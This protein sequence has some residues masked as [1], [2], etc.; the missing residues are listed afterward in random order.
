MDHFYDPAIESLL[1]SPIHSKRWQAALDIAQM[2]AAAVDAALQDGTVGDALRILNSSAARRDNLRIYLEYLLPIADGT[3][4]AGP[5][6]V[7]AWYRRNFRIVANLDRVAED[8]DRVGIVYGA[9][10]VPVLE[11]IL[12]GHSRYD[13]IDPT[14]YLN[15]S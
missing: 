13:V 10:H 7:G 12:Q 14:P 6:M 15:D 1:Q 9:G 8:G 4:W 11:H 2:Q 3:N 5:D